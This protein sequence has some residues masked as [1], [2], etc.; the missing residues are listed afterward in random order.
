M[1]KF[2]CTVCH[3][4][5]GGAIDFTLAGHTPNDA[6]QDRQWRQEHG[7]NASKGSAMGANRFVESS[8]L[9][10]HPQVTDLIREGVKEEAPKL[11]KGYNLVRELGCFGCHDITGYKDGRPIGPDMRLE[12]ASTAERRMAGDDDPTLPPGTYRKVGP[13]LRKLADK[14]DEEWTRRWLL[15][16]RGFRPDTRMPHFYNVGTNSPR[17]PGGNRSG[18]IPRR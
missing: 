11:L 16:P 3:E 5:E 14:T 8:C 9:K 12:P 17:S 10:C 7:D 18:E 6:L 1:N 15:A 2:G 13:S 4:G